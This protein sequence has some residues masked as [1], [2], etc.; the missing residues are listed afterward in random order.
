MTSVD[1]RFLERGVLGM[2]EAAWERLRLQDQVIGPLAA[3]ATVT[4]GAADS[5]AEEF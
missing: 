1:P 3:L 4:H 5:A 2:G